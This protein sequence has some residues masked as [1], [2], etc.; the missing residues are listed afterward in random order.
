LK[1]IRSWAAT[2]GKYSMVIKEVIKK[3]LSPAQARVKALN[4]QAKRLR[5]QAKQAKAQQRLRKAQADLAR[6]NAPIPPSNAV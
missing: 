1:D 5:D 6:A 2:A 4:D 3:P